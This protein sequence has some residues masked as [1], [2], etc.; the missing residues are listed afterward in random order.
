MDLQP[1]R[2]MDPFQFF[3]T[4]CLMKY[5]KIPKKVCQS[6]Q[7]IILQSSFILVRKEQCLNKWKNYKIQICLSSLFIIIESIYWKDFTP[8]S[9]ALWEAWQWRLLQ[10][11]NASSVSRELCPLDELNQYCSQ[12]VNRNFCSLRKTAWHSFSTTDYMCNLTHQLAQV[13]KEWKPVF[14]FPS[15]NMYILWF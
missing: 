2:S 6:H 3:E 8:K 11:G 9:W 1:S 12:I 15:E 7:L 4:S 14:F 5:W 13:R 10:W